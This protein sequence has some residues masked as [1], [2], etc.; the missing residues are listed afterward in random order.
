MLVQVIIIITRD[1]DGHL[2]IRNKNGI[3]PREASGRK[4]NFAGERKQLCLTD[5]F[6]I[7][8]QNACASYQ[9]YRCPP[10]QSEEPAPGDSAREARGGYRVKWLGEILAGFRHPLRGRATS[11][12]GEPLCVRA[13]IPRSNGK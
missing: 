2:H 11:L 10:A 5:R 8:R 4:G 7:P 1:Y 6:D 9:S 12:R 3:S 13:A